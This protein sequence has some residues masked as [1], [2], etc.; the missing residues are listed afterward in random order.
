MNTKK[1][2]YD[3]CL[4]NTTNYTL[5]KLGAPWCGPCKRVQP[6]FDN[7]ARSGKYKNTHIFSLNIDNEEHDPDSSLRDMMKELGLSCIP[8]FFICY[9]GIKIA[10]IQTSNGNTLETFLD[11]HLPHD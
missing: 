11:E 10:S 3:Y 9:D 8:H 6:Y 1:D 5:F 4:A 2:V 7:L